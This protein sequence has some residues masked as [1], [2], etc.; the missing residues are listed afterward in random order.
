MLKMSWENMRNI[1]HLQEK[2]QFAKSVSCYND[3]AI[4]QNNRASKL[5]CFRIIL[6]LTDLTDSR[7]ANTVQHVKNTCFMCLKLFIHVCNNHVFNYDGLHFTCNSSLAL[8]PFNFLYYWTIK[9]KPE[10]EKR[11]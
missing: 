9:T 5:Y 10:L 1:P 8:K 6:R 4:I 11:G 3:Y 7:G 2:G